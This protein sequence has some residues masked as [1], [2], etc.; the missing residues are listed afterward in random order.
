[1]MLA[2]DP[3]GPDLSTFYNR[4]G[5]YT[6]GTYYTNPATGGIDGGGYSYSGTLLGTSQSWSNTLFTFG[7]LNATNVI[8]CTNQT[9]PLPPGNYSRL[10]ILGTAVN[11]SYASQQFFL[12]YTDVTNSLFQGLSDWFSPQGYSGE[13]KAIPMGYRNSSD[14][15][16][17]ENSALY[18]YGYNIALNS[19]KTLQ[20][21][22][23]PNN[24]NVIITAISLV[25]NWPPTFKVSP[26]TYPS[27]NSGASYGGTI[28]TNASDLNGD[29][30]TYAKISGPAWLNVAA[31]GTLSGTPSDSDANTNTFVMSVKD[32]GGLSNT[33]TLFIYVNGTPSFTV[34]PFSLPGITAGQNY[35]GEIDTN[36][37]DPNPSDVLTF[38]SVSGPAWLTVSANGQLSGTPLSGDVGDNTF[39]VSVTDAGGLSNTATLDIIVSAAPPIVSTIAPQPDGTLQL[40]WSGGIAPFQV[41]ATADLTTPD[42]QNLGAP[43]SGNSLFVTPTND[44]MFYRIMGQ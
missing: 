24:P 30:L 40:N 26:L 1:M 14:G 21:I 44:T 39:I 11:G 7:P 35:S 3:V 34:N 31:N 27:V 32:S 37:T 6:D 2:S 4:A 16:S 43:F 15:S 17:G 19:T 20:N 36:A 5:I 23:L 41:Q 18:L 33:M 22:R 38:A 29:V 9:I 25:P 8:S 10:R 12:G 42:W 13:T 28:A